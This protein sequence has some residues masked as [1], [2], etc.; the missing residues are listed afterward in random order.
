MKIK[1]SVI[2]VSWN[3]VDYLR[4]C[5]DSLLAQPGLRY[6]AEGGHYLLNGASLE[7]IVV[8]N[9]SV[10]GTMAT[11]H[12]DYPHV[13]AIASGANLGFTGGNNLGIE[14]AGGEYL[15]LLNP[16]TELP[17]KGRGQGSLQT[18]LD[19]MEDHPQVGLLGPRLVYGDGSPQPSCRRFPTLMMACCEST[20][21]EQ[22]WP[23]NRWA[24]RYRMADCSPDE[25]RAVDWVTGACMLLRR[26]AL[27]RVGLFDRGYFMYSEELDLCRRL[28]KA[29]W[30]VIYLGRSLVVHHEAKS[31]GQVVAKRQIYFNRSKIRYFA[32]HHGRPQAL[33]LRLFLGATFLVS[34]GI[35]TIKYLLRHKPELRRQRMS[36]YVKVIAALWCSRN[37]AMEESP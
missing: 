19:Y 33:A 11:L 36:A 12:R 31:S 16:D 15:L 5:L 32:K 34:L 27:D 37:R 8:D 9:D 30:R 26:Q 6:D 3:V 22:W 13:R 24:R 17:P 35:E 10:D 7:I 1:L 2:I 29:G 14:Q 21:V 20:L 18:M 23:G 28:V 25:T 4:A